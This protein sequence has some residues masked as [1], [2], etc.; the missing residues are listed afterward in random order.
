MI[1]VVLSALM[2]AMTAVDVGYN[3]YSTNET[4]KASDVYNRYV[5]GFY[6]SAEKENASYFARYLRAHHLDPKD[7][8][9]PFRTGMNF[10][11]SQLYSA[12]V[13]DVSNQYARIGSYVHGATRLGQSASLGAYNSTK[14]SKPNTMILYPGGGYYGY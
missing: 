11:E 8:K 10:N 7:V 4:T 2:L 5:E 14:P 6:G 3:I 9:Y 12:G 13:R 1:P